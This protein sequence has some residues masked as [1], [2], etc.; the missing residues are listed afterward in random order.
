[1]K[2]KLQFGKNIKVKYKEKIS[3]QNSLHSHRQQRDSDH[4]QIQDV[5][6]VTAEG[7]RVHERSVYRHLSV[8]FIAVINNS[9]WILQFRF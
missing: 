4:N 3:R 1:M 5:E 7:A 2:E 9:S 8:R 6:G